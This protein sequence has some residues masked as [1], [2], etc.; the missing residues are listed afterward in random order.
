MLKKTY[1]FFYNAA[2]IFI[3]MFANLLILTSVLFLLNIPMSFFHLPISCVL[4]IL[5]LFF[6]KKDD[7]KTIL[8]SAL[9]FVLIFISSCL[10]SGHIYDSSADGNGYHKVAVGLLK[11]GWNPIYDS[12]EEYIKKLNLNTKENVWVEHYP[13]AT[14]IYGASVYSL[15]DNIETAKS[16]NLMTLIALFF[17]IAYLINKYYNKHIIAFLLAISA[18]TFPIIWQQ[19]FCLYLDGLMG[20]ILLLL[21]IFFYLFVKNDTNKEYFITSA[22]LMIIIINIKF[23]GLFYAG[24]FCLGYFIYYIITKIKNQE[25]VKLVKTTLSFSIVVLIAVL[26]V[27]SNSYVKNLITEHNPL[28]P[29]IGK[30]K[31]D[32]ITPQQPEMFADL[33]PIEKNFY[34]IFS[35]TANYAT[36]FNPGTPE[37]KIP[38]TVNKELEIYNIVEDTRVGG[39]GLYFSGIFI[40]A[41]IIILISIIYFIKKKNYSKL[42]F[43]GIPF[44]ITILLM[45]FFGESWWARYSPQT[46]FLVLA[47]IFLLLTSN[48]KKCLIIGFLLVLLCCYNS[49]IIVKQ[50]IN[51]KIPISGQI[52]ENLENLENKNVTIEKGGYVGVLFNL[53]DYNIKFSFKKEIKNKEPL[54]IGKNYYEKK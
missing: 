19:M 48:N 28:Y 1:N 20:L 25:K 46:Y 33:S 37:L 44:T 36:A 41:L 30:D 39:F 18:C 45:L 8:I 43:I 22:A 54:Y 16:F 40:I 14:W 29:I 2:L 12:Q 31:I 49:T 21:L 38:F 52:R 6:I 35:F 50:M 24:I 17:V 23:T 47:A 15:T 9:L 42:I 13:K 10:I 26:I 32:I 7:I 11:N 27:G 51:S 5:E 3:L 34:S 4:A 53:K